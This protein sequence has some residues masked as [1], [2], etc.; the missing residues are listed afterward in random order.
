MAY[1]FTD[2]IV[3]LPAIGRVD[4]AAVS[5]AYP[6]MLAH[7]VDPTDG[8]GEF[9]YLQGVINCVLG[10][11]VT[12]AQGSP[13][14]LAAVAAHGSLVAVAMAATGANQFGWFMI[15]GLARMAKTATAATA[16]QGVA[17]SGTAGSVAALALATPLG[18]GT[19]AGAVVAANAL[20][21]DATVAVQLSRSII[22]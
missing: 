2:E 20:S 13:V 10:S 9:I 1:T 21:G 18:S 6:G 5:P 12:Y 15:T 22:A 17:I 3:G 16:G 19:I 14:T 4:S 7:A 11:A 8:G